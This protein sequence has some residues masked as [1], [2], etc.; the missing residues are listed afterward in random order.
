[1]FL[2]RT[3]RP[4]LGRRC[5]RQLVSE[6]SSGRDLDQ[7]QEVALS[8]Q[9]LP[10]SLL[11]CLACPVALAVAFSFPL[12]LFPA[13]QILRVLAA[14]TLRHLCGH[15]PGVLSP[16]TAL[17]PHGGS[18]TA[19]ASYRALES[20]TAGSIGNASKEQSQ[21]PEAQP[22]TLWSSLGRLRG[23][24]GRVLLVVILALLASTLVDYLA[25]VQ[26]SPC[27]QGSTRSSGT[28]TLLLSSAS[29]Y[30]RIVRLFQPPHSSVHA[31]AQVVSLLG[32]VLGIPVAIIMPPLLHLRLC[33]PRGGWPE[34]SLVRAADLVAA[35]IGTC[36]SVACASITIYTW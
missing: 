31:V 18:T 7:L 27:L 36:L 24:V 2:R 20:F 33:A 30:I 21:P 1:M 28:R 26:R 12:Q 8:A 32:A 35:A 14:D 15:R 34:G 4:G 19:E 9:T 5:L 13:V 23:D 29:T 17:S 6:H 11:F 10:P 25:K 16:R 3:W 22:Q